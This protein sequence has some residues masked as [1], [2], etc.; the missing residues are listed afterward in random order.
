MPKKVDIY[1]SSIELPDDVA[2][3]MIKARD[4]DKDERRKMAERIGAIEAQA[5]AAE[6]KARQEAEAAELAKLT[7]KGEF[8]KALAIERE[9]FAKQHG[10]LSQRLRDQALE[11]QIA[12]AKGV[13]PAAVKDIA[14]QLRQG[15]SY[16]PEKD[17]LVFTDA[18]GRPLLG[19][20]GKPVTADAAIDGYLADRPWFRAPSGAPGSGSAPGG[21][22]PAGSA[23]L[24]PRDPDRRVE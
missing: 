20:D 16:D 10:A 18:G 17:Q 3:A 2:D 19:N 1:G 23:T 4:A 21:G 9:K 14:Q 6:D 22:P 15:C 13:L 8:E 7:S 24:T 12:R 5:K 11:A